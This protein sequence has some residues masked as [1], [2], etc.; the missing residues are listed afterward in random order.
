MAYLNLHMDFFQ[1]RSIRQL[2]PILHQVN[3]DL[4]FFV[5]RYAA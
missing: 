2:G 3:K 5:I 1:G 4:R